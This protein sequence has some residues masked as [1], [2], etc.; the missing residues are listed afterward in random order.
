MIEKLINFALNQR[1]LTIAA[2]LGLACFGIFSMLSLPVDSF[3]DVSNVQVQIITEPESMATEEVEALVTYPIEN[4]LNG[5]PKVKKIRS[6]SSF[7]LSV[8]T[9]IF[10]DD[11]D[12]YFA[13][14]LIMQRLFQTDKLLPRRLP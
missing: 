5:L 4:I 10:D 9:A 7:G 2:A 12:V 6:S 11:M 14:N 13:R 1:L 3:P 8:V